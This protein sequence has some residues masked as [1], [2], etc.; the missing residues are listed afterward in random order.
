MNENK[1]LI[2]DLLK[3]LLKLREKHKEDKA[4]FDLSFYIVITQFFVNYFG[5]PQD[6]LESVEEAGWDET[7][8]KE[9]VLK[10]FIIFVKS[11]YT[12]VWENK[13][14]EIDNIINNY[15]KLK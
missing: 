14:E 13:K 5:F 12:A 3:I 9:S 1:E 11:L 8:V 15:F 4:L 2:E 10:E 7:K 6:F